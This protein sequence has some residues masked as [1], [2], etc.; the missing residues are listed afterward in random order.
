MLLLFI[1]FTLAHA[2]V[3]FISFYTYKI[4][5]TYS[6]FEHSSECPTCRRRLGENDFTELVVADSSGKDIAK[7]NMQS[8]F[9]KKSGSGSLH[10]SDVCQSLIQQIECS[11]QSTKFLLKQLLVESHRAGRTSLQG[12][13]EKQQLKAENT[14]LK[15]LNSSQRLQFEQTLNDMQNKLKARESTIQEQNRMIDNF[16]KLQGGRG[17]GGGSIAPPPHMVP[18]SSSASLASSR[19]PEPP[20]RGLM[21]QRAANEK[22][23]QN[24]MNGGVKR[25]FMNNMHRN[26][27]PGSSF[28]PFSSGT[29]SAGGSVA[30]SA[31]R[32]RDLTANSGYHFTGIPNQQMNK[33]RRGG[34]PNSR[35]NVTPHHAMSPNTA[36]ALNQGGS[37]NGRNMFQR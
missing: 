15:Q 24:V 8:L 21:A 9:S 12:A 32:I 35:D 27:S 31:P 11:K 28:R 16:R 37:L 29:S 25:S 10:Y 19:G 20:L 2:N 33:R 5:C 22:A 34:T 36:F 30:S 3:T 6:H 7:S 17:P 14:H 18:H 23:Q 26:K 1:C 4:E 13:R